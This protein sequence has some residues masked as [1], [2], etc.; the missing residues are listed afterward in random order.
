MLPGGC[1]ASAST[2]LNFSELNTVLVVLLCT[3]RG[4]RHQRPRNTRYRAGATP[5][6]NRTFTGWIAPASPGAHELFKA[7]VDSVIAG[8]DGKGPVPNLTPGPVC[9]PNHV[10]CVRTEDAKLSR[11]F[12]PSGGVPDQWELY[13]LA[14]DPTEAVNLV[15]VEGTS[16]TRRGTTCRTGPPRPRF[17]AWPT[18]STPCWGTWK[19]ATF[20]PC[21]RTC[22][23]PDPPPP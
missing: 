4:R 8:S 3:L 18:A 11:Y 5:Y 7:V 21:R 10:R 14:K 19:S 6:P 13:N 16:P 22:R 9:Q 1:S 23:H 17:R 2:T 12:D 20:P 15:Q